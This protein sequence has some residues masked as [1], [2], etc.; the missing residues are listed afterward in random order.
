M[1]TSTSSSPI[2]SPQITCP[3]CGGANDHD[4]IFCGNPQCH[5]ALGDFDYV[6]EELK[7][8][9]RWHETLAQHVTNIIS[10]PGFVAGHIVWFVL[11]IAI[12][13]GVIM[14]VHAFDRAPF[15]IL[16][17]IVSIR[18]GFDHNFRDNIAIKTEQTCRQA[19]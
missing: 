14:A 3:A 12:N 13:T 6:L 8:E 18:I 7:A 9:S 15:G 19:R 4:A 11:W 16:A 1:S 2:G 10:R 5:K 17:F